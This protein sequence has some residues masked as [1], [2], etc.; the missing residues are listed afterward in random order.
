MMRR[1]SFHPQLQQDFN[2]ILD[3][4]ESEAGL[5][6]AARFETEF[7]NAVEAVKRQP[8]HFAYYLNQRRFR[9]CKLPTFPHVL[10]YRETDLVLRF[11]VLKHVKRSPGYGL[12]RK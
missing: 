1:V 6:V 2:D 7:R 4:Y 10:L 3:H 12:G 8:R 5:E 11:I 9:R